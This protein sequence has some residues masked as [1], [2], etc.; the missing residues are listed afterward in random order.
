M[1]VC[2]SRQAFATQS[3]LY[4]Q[5]SARSPKYGG[6]HAPGNFRSPARLKAPWNAVLNLLPL[7]G[8]GGAAH[9]TCR[10][11][12][13]NTSPSPMRKICQ[14]GH[15]VPV[16]RHAARGDRFWFWGTKA[17]ARAR[18]TQCQSSH[19]ASTGPG[20]GIKQK[21]YDRPKVRRAGGNEPWR[22]HPGISQWTISGGAFG[23]RIFCVAPAN[24]IIADRGE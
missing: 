24:L 13:R 15:K 11:A 14:L 1:Q 16:Q 22:L 10:R 17:W 23:R 8:G 7:R 19:S 4:A 6:S 9:M 5:H 20:A 21:H 2:A 3:S 12:C 18:S